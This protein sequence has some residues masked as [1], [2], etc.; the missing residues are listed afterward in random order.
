MTERH[1]G[2]YYLGNS[3]LIMVG[4]W[5]LDGW[6]F[7]TA[8]FDFLSDSFS[9]R[10]GGD[11]FS[12]IQSQRFLYYQIYAIVYVKHTG[13]ILIF[14]C[15]PPPTRY[16]IYYWYSSSWSSPKLN[17]KICYTITTESNWVKYKLGSGHLVLAMGMMELL[18]GNSKKFHPPTC[19]WNKSN[20]PE[21]H[22]ISPS[23]YFTSFIYFNCF[24][25][26][27]PYYDIY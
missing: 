8:G 27:W 2:I 10:G 3:Y 21:V 13:L 26:K 24:S 18:V 9:E 7:V 4:T 15:S 25:W 17:C 11:L 14:Q 22:K 19:T 20:I 1:T 6:H 23:S 5:K 16:I 12:N